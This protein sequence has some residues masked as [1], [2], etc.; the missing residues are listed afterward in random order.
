MHLYGKV[1]SIHFYFTSTEITREKKKKKKQ[2]SSDMNSCCTHHTAII[3]TN[4]S[5]W[6]SL[7]LMKKIGETKLSFARSHKTTVLRSRFN[8]YDLSRTE[9]RPQGNSHISFWS[10]ITV[11]RNTHMQ[12]M[13]SKNDRKHFCDQGYGQDV[14]SNSGQM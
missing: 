8:L 13:P 2:C 11:A 1:C 3:Y 10:E 12:C 7:V 6:Y 9:H 14:I 5:F 4:I